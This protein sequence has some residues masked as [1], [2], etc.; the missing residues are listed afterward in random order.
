[1]D[2]NVQ[3]FNCTGSVAF[4]SVANGSVIHGN[5]QCLNNTGPCNLANAT[6]GGSVQ[7]INNVT[8]SGSQIYSNR[9]FG[10][11]QCQNNSVAPTNFGYVNTVSGV[12]QGQ[13]AG[14]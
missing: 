10:N 11:L 13:C 3:I 2:G 8:S 1:M 7:F 6:V 12:E 14:L 4:L 5:F 9:I